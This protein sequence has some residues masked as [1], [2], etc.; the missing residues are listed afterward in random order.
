MISHYLYPGFTNVEVLHTCSDRCCSFLRSYFTC[1]ISRQNTGHSSFRIP[2][3]PRTTSIKTI[4]F[5]SSAPV[6][7]D[8]SS[9]V[10]NHDKELTRS[11]WSLK[12]K[13]RVSLNRHKQLSWSCKS[14][15]LDQ[16][17]H[18]S[19]PLQAQSRL[20]LLWVPYHWVLSGYHKRPRG[21]INC[22]EI[23]Y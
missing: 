20:R 3:T 1:L 10:N 7:V 12:L 15:H 8:M 18:Q 13:I 11:N 22:P 5:V 2:G 17:P 4:F 16:L 14:A 9:D 6:Q 19:L 23:E 21:S